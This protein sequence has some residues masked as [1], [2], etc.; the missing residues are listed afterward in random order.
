[1][2]VTRTRP[3]RDRTCRRVAVP[4]ALALAVLAGAAASAVAAPAPQSAPRTPPA[5]A[6]AERYATR[7]PTGRFGTVTVYIPRRHTAE[8]RDLCLR[9]WRLGARGD[10]HGARAPRHGR[11]GDR[12]RHPPV[13]RQRAQ[14]GA[15]PGRAL[16]DDCSRFRSPEPPG[17]EGDRHERVPRAGA[18]RV[19]LR[20]HGGVRGAGAVAAGHLRRRS[21]PRLLRR[22]GF[23]RCGAVS[24]SGPALQPEPTARAGVRAGSHSEAA[25]DRAPGAEGPGLR[26]ACRG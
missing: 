10:R 8:R 14:G 6:A 16:P 7:L 22:P 15:T 4:V 5:A 25:V 13:L 2:I 26:P 17:A 9:R 3:W 11:R 18:G 24:G 19:L 21:E 23:R 12:R 1:M 20:C